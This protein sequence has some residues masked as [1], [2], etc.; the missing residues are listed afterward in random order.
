MYLFP[1]LVIILLVTTGLLI[2]PFYLIFHLN[3]VGFSF[4]GFIKVKWFGIILYKKYLHFPED[5]EDGRG[6]KNGKKPWG[7]IRRGDKNAVDGESKPV[8]AWFP[9]D[10]HILIDIISAF[11]RVLKGLK[12]TI[13]V[14]NILCKV[15]LGLNDPAD[16]AIVCGYLWALTSSVSLP[17]YFQVYP[18]FEGEKL[19][20]SMNAKI[21]GRLLWILI[22]SINALSEK[23]I[24]QLLRRTSL[25]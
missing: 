11:F 7:K 6:V 3:I 16:T 22:A 18:H 12:D 13:Y 5:T 4:Y 21:R 24:R 9:K 25:G 20:G 8:H 10:A 23:P 14:E 15:T 17:N 2:V 1:L 19:D